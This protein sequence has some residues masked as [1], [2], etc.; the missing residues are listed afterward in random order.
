MNRSF[1]QPS[2]Q[3]LIKWSA[4]QRRW[5]NNGRRKSSPLSVSRSRRPSSKGTVSAQGMV[6]NTP[7]SRDHFV[8]EFLP[9]T[10]VE[11]RTEKRRQMS[12]ARGWCEEREH[13]LV[14]APDH[15]V[16]WRVKRAHFQCRCSAC[17]RQSVASLK[18]VV[19]RRAALQGYSPSYGWNQYSSDRAGGSTQSR[20]ILLPLCRS[21]PVGRPQRGVRRD[22]ACADIDRI[23]L[24]LEQ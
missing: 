4:W 17:D 7:L 1:H 20:L 24:R 11:S 19:F 5:P 21:E 23:V 18:R 16:R 10:R 22:R 9:P 8:G 14:A 6:L 12:E 2:Y 13:D 3:R 15:Y